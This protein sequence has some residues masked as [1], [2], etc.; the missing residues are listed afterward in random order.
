MKCDMHVIGES[1]PF[2]PFFPLPSAFVDYVPTPISSSVGKDSGFLNTVLASASGSC[3]SVQVLNHHLQKDQGSLAVFFPDPIKFGSLT[4]HRIL[5]SSGFSPGGFSTG[6]HPQI[7]SSGLLSF[8][9]SDFPARRCSTTVPF[10]AAV[11]ANRA[12]PEEGPPQILLGIH[13]ESVLR[14]HQTTSSPSELDEELHEDQDR[15]RSTKVSWITFWLSWVGW[16][17]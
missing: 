14:R 10:P 3:L 6:L 12:V 4:D 1:S 17:G 13:M 15:P 2:F 11:S 5:S 9:S 16:F 7:I 8:S